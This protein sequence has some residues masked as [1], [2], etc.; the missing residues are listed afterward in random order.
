[1]TENKTKKEYKISD[2]Y[3]FNKETIEHLEFKEEWYLLEFPLYL[4]YLTFK[5]GDSK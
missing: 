4:D 1:M 2:E 5:K 3:D